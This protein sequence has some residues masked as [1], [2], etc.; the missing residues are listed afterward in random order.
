MTS[1]IYRKYPKFVSLLKSRA[2]KYNQSHEKILE[3]EKQNKLFLI[4]PDNHPL[5]KNRTETNPKKIR[6]LHDLGYNTA[7]STFENLKK[8]IDAEQGE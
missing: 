8:Y 7:K 4:A 1:L 6:E 2:E 3:Y 5:E